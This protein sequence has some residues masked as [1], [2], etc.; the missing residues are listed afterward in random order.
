M[1]KLYLHFKISAVWG[2]FVIFIWVGVLV[3][4]CLFFGVGSLFVVFGSFVVCV[5]FW[6]LFG[7]LVGWVG[8]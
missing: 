8:F 5:V 1:G 3:F 2:G 6:V 7:W 4:F